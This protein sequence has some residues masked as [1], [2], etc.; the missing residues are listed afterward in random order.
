MGNP[1]FTEKGAGSKVFKSQAASIP[2]PEA[3]NK[4]LF[5]TSSL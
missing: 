2:S 3:E 5:S 1:T 4:V